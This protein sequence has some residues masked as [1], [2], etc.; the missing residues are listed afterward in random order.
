MIDRFRG[1]KSQ[2]LVAAQPVFSGLAASE[3]PRQQIIQTYFGLDRLRVP[4]LSAADKNRDIGYALVV[5]SCEG[6]NNVDACT[7]TAP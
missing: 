6:L 2:L 7:V 1:A 5:G 4:T 3:S